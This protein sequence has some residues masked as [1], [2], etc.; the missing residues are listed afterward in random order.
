MERM[1]I[2]KEKLPL[3]RCSVPDITMP[4]CLYNHSQQLQGWADGTRSNA[5]NLKSQRRKEGY[6]KEGM[7]GKQE[8]LWNPHHSMRTREGSSD[9][10]E[11]QSSQINSVHLSLI[12]T[13]T[14]LTVIR[15]LKPGSSTYFL[16][17]YCIGFTGPRCHTSWAWI[18]K[19]DPTK[20]FSKKK[21][22]F[23]IEDDCF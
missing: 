19:H 8:G 2:S 16:Q 9:C 7:G 21:K 6:K 5:M 12:V 11:D 15:A 23:N 3:L 18:E 17:I 13:N 14:I 20:I 10:A 4:P 1:E 22:N